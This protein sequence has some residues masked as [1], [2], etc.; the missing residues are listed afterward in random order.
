LDG[1]FTARPASEA[2][3]LE[4]FESWSDVTDAALLRAHALLPGVDGIQ[5]LLCE[6]VRKN[7]VGMK[8][9]LAG[10]DS[11]RTCAA[12]QAER[13]ALNKAPRRAPREGVRARAAR[14]NAGTLRRSWCTPSPRRPRH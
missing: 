7:T 3:A 14:K 10:H 13:A 2:D 4:F 11:G 6:R 8:P 5:V 9:N 12:L 1:E